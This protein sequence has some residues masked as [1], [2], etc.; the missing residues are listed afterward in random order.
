MR[1]RAFRRHPFVGSFSG[2]SLYDYF[3]LLQDRLSRMG[4]SAVP[5]SDGAAVACQGTPVLP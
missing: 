1:N 4:Q 5:R 3:D 2:R